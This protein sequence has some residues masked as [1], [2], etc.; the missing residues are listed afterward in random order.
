MAKKKKAGSWKDKSIYEIIAPENFDSISLGT[1]VASSPALLPGRSVDVSLKNLTGDRGKQHLKV[2]FEIDKVE[3][4]KAHS[5]FKLFEI[6]A[7]YLKSKIR[8]GCS[9]IDYTDRVDFKNQKVKI[10][11]MTVTHKHIQSSQKKEI[12]AK[13]SAIIKA[14]RKDNLNE[15]A[16]AALFG[17]LGTEIY[18]GIKNICP[19]R[20]VEVEWLEVL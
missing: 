18:H 12:I 5:S 17:K 4:N 3:H 11:V 6:N 19:V 1:T 20:R 16:Q 15:F 14:H 8:K 9:K 10:K 2:V 13:I 7:G